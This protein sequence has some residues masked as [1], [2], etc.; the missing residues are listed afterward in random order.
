MD[1]ELRPKQV[2][3]YSQKN[4][5]VS[6]DDSELG[7]AIVI[8]EWLQT[9]QHDNRWILTAGLGKFT[10]YVFP[11]SISRVRNML[12]TVVEYEKSLKQ[13][14]AKSD[15]DELADKIDKL[16]ISASSTATL[17]SAEKR[18]PI[19]TH[20]GL[21]T[22]IILSAKETYDV[23]YYK[24]QI[25]FS[26]TSRRQGQNKYFAY[27]GLKFEH[28]LKG[29]ESIPY[30]DHFKVLFK[31]YFG[32]ISYLSV[33]EIDGATSDYNTSLPAEEKVKHYIEIKMCKCS[34]TPHFEPS[35]SAKDKLQWLKRNAKGFHHKVKK[36]LFQSYFARQDTLVIGLRNDDSIVI[37]AFS[38]TMPELIKFVQESFPSLYKTFQERDSIIASALESVSDFVQKNKKDEIQQNVFRFNTQTGQ[39]CVIHHPRVFER[40]LSPEFL[41]WRENNEPLQC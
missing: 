38:V 30:N 28:L 29:D 37:C 18:I 20:N 33:A 27:I 31:G 25:I 7:A 9:G 17:T 5:V 12:L 36:Y 8:P 19:L 3:C 32:D 10:P 16:N 41:E 11:K 4:G 23:V 39:T 15:A 34:A 1:A 40:V 24:G 2:F 21:F 26:S 13:A 22:D 35:T 6:F 14:V